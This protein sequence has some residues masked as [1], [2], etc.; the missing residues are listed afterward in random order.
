MTDDTKTVVANT[1]PA[2]LVDHNLVP[3]QIVPGILYDKRPAKRLDG[4]TAEGIYNVW[5]TLDNPKQYN[6]YT[7]EMVKGAILA[8]RRA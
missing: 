7:T 3:E 8:F 6:S 1:K 2:E 4:S 5:I